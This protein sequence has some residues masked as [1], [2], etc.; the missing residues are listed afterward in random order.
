MAL[1]GKGVGRILRL[2]LAVSGCLLV[3]V[4]PLT[5]GAADSAASNLSPSSLEDELG[6]LQE[7]T[8][9]YSASRHEENLFQADSAAFVI[10]AAD[11]SSSGATSIS[12]AIMVSGEAYKTRLEDTWPLIDNSAPPYYYV[13]RRDTDND[14]LNSTARW[15]NQL[16]A[17]NEISSQLYLAY[18][19]LDM[20]IFRE[21][22]TTYDPDLQHRLQL[23]PYLTHTWGAGYRYSHDRIENSSVAIY[24]PASR[25][26]AKYSFFL[27]EEIVLARE[28]VVLTLGC[29]LDYS[30]PSHD[31]WQPTARLLITPSP[32]QT[33]WLAVSQAKRLPS[34][35]ELD[36][37]NISPES[38][39]QSISPLLPPGNVMYLALQ[40]NPELAA[41]KVVAYEA[42]Y[43]LR[44]SRSV[45]I[46]TAFFYNRYDDLISI[47]EGGDRVIVNASIPYERYTLNRENGMAGHTYGVEAALTWDIALW[48]QLKGAYSFLYGSLEDNNDDNNTDAS[49]PSH[50]ASLLSSQDFGSWIFNNWL[51]YNGEME[52]GHGTAPAYWSLNSN[53]IYQATAQLALMVGAES[54]PQ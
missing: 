34:R 49:T 44:P 26:F 50:Q 51:R 11:I 29:K 39:Q 3:V 22:R 27:Q 28:L 4:S 14:G 37:I 52:T 43:R 48:W 2:L 24:E 46:D 45:E 36:L 42:G 8:I 19:D 41:E 53:L 7:K 16:S 21:Q 6:W 17:N 54:V 10:S 31:A 30:A 40:G 38:S 5:S 15:T 25:S 13:D 12:N 35:T 23:T 9:L 1:G 47:S 32:R 33:L 18:T 20:V